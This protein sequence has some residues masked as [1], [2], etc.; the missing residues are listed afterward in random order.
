[1]SKVM[2][3]THED[4]E[5]VLNQFNKL[6]NELL[7]GT[8]NRNTFRPWEVEL[9]IDIEV[10]NLRDGNKRETLRRYMRSVQRHME[11]GAPSPMKLSEYLE[12]LRVKRE[13]RGL[14]GA[15]N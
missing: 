10:C 5:L 11:K 14:V 7:K 13:N 15:A 1:M 2:V 4:S 6:I 12:G 3:E 8:L 9:L